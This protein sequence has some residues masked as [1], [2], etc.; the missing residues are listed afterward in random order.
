MQCID[1]GEW[2]LNSKWLQ[3]L[4]ESNN[5]LK[6]I[7]GRVNDNVRILIQVR[8]KAFKA[9]FN[10]STDNLSN[11]LLNLPCINFWDK[12]R[13]N[14]NI[15]TKH[16]TITFSLYINIFGIKYKNL[17]RNNTFTQQVQSWKGLSDKSYKLHSSSLSYIYAIP[18]DIPAAK[19]LP[20]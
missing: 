18:P 17:C 13:I 1:G 8:N 3:F 11:I 9:L 6:W 5:L 2:H 14:I 20:V 15:L 16:G 10:P 7:N 12:D 19:F 4:E